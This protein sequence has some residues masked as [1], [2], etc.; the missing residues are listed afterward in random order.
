MTVEEDLRSA[1][2]REW[3]YQLPDAPSTL[4]TRQRWEEEREM[5]CERRS[6]WRDCDIFVVVGCGGGFSGKV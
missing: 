3:P 1:A 4:V 5:W 2:R 6:W